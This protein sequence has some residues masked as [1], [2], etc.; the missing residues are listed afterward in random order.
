MVDG[1]SASLAETCAI[2]SAVGDLPIKQG[3]AMTGSMNQKG[4]VQPIG[5]VNQ[6]VEGFHDVC[7]AV[8]FTG[9]QG[10]IVPSRNL[11]NLMLRADAVESVRE[12]KFRVWEV[13]TIEEAL[14]V[15]TGMP[16]GERDEHGK[17]PE[18]TVHHAVEKKLLE[19]GETLKKAAAAKGKK[20]DA[21]EE[22]AGE[23][24][25]AEEEKKPRRRGPKPPGPR[26][27]K[28]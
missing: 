19:M 4:E 24:Q 3:I 15:L 11:K 25:P 18:G 1:D 13:S 28:K 20:K 5:G 8:G 22:G 23:E 26:D 17:Y 10:V 16:A 27:E 6:K 12:G 9:E 2:L 21:K 7:K 14:E